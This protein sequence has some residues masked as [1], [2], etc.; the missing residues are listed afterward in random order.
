MPPL[1]LRTLDRQSR[2][3]PTPTYAAVTQ[4]DAVRRNPEDVSS[5]RVSGIFDAETVGNNSTTVVDTRVNTTGDSASVGEDY[6]NYNTFGSNDNDLGWTT[7]TRRRARSMEDLQE[8]TRA[9]RKAENSLTSTQRAAIRMRNE[10]LH[11]QEG[12]DSEDTDSTSEEDLPAK[13]SVKG[14]NVD[15]RA[16]VEDATDS[17]D[18]QPNQN[19][20]ED[21]M[22][23]LRNSGDPDMDPEAQR[24]ALETWN[25]DRDAG[26]QVNAMRTKAGMASGSGSNNRE[27]A[28]RHPGVPVRDRTEDQS[29]DEPVEK[30][31][32]KRT[33]KRRSRSRSRSKSKSKGKKS[34]DKKK[35]KSRSRSKKRKDTLKPM[36]SHYERKL[37]EAVRGNSSTPNT[38]QGED[39]RKRPNPKG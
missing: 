36:S 20:E 13:T 30:K 2:N 10:K 29:S 7:V 34:K 17:E 5:P 39:V 12:T 15:R 1:L 8:Q 6:T 14:K 32:K 19:L 26:I 18:E 16:R 37:E 4:A 25:A 31:K 3:E 11:Y 28:V 22:E 27:D 33:S 35:T 9:I 21:F 24:V 23:N 38:H